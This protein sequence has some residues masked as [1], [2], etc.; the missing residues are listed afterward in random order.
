MSTCFTFTSPIF[1]PKSWKYWPAGRMRIFLTLCNEIISPARHLLP[2]SN[3]PTIIN[4]CRSVPFVHFAFSVFSVLYDILKFIQLTLHGFIKFDC[5]SHS[6]LDT[7]FF[8][9]ARNGHWMKNSLSWRSTY[10][11]L[12]TLYSLYLKTFKTWTVACTGWT[13]F[14]H[15]RME[16]LRFHNLYLNLL[17]SIIH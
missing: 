9:F 1:L 16:Q 8:S 14:L 6:V 10:F 13:L 4:Q 3:P 2:P 17:T 7:V 11:T 5:S 12:R 15:F